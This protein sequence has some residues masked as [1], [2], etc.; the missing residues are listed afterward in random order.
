MRR[1]FLVAALAAAPFATAAAQVSGTWSVEYVR[2]VRNLNGEE[3]VLRGKAK[4]WLQ[5]KG[6]SVTGTWEQ[7]DPAPRQAGARKVWGVV[8]NGTVKLQAEPTEAIRNENGV[9]EKVKIFNSY[10]LRID[11]DTV[12]GT[13]ST[14]SEDGSIAPPPRPVNG[15][16]IKA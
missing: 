5:Q 6:D 2:G 14:K 12:T 9:E 15:T 8:S 1:L 10:E 4:V 3:E 16:R 7:V 11:G 13:Q